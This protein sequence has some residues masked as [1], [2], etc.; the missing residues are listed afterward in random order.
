MLH[1]NLAAQNFELTNLNIIQQQINSSQKASHQ[2]EWLAAYF[3]QD[4]VSLK[5]FHK[6]FRESSE[7]ERELWFKLSKYIV[8]RGGEVQ[9]K[10]VDYLQ[11]KFNSVTEAVQFALGL[12]KELNQ[13]YLKLE[14]SA[15]ELHDAH[16]NHFV[17]NKILQEYV[18][19]IKK[20]SDMITQLHRVSSTGLGVY[21]FNLRLLE[22]EGH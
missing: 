4:N 11:P 3:D 19:S 17:K 20:R 15:L 1:T 22:E 18:E 7:E 9:F 8:E 10:T 16:L 14:F 12:D 21:L 2:F 6:F 13:S 5:G